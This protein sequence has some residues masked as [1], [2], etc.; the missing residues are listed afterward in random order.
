MTIHDSYVVLIGFLNGRKFK[1]C[2]GL[3]LLIIYMQEGCA[4]KRSPRLGTLIKRDG[5]VYR[6]R[7]EVN[8]GILFGQK[9][10]LLKYWGLE[11]IPW[12]NFELSMVRVVV[13]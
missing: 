6:R 5:S 10:F 11:Q 4:N 3:Y 9:I 2:C 8:R 13:L 7:A 1:S 12:D